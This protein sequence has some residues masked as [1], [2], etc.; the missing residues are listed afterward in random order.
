MSKTIL[1]VGGAGYIGSHTN[2]AL[3]EKGYKTIV[4]DN[5]SRGHLSAVSVDSEF[6]QGDL[7][8]VESIRGVFKTH[9]IDGV[10]DFAAS[11]E[12]GESQLNPQLYYYNNVVNSLNLFQVMLEFG[13]KNIVFSSTAATYGLPEVTPITESTPNKPINTYG[14]TKLMIEQILSDYHRA[15]NLNSI[16]LRYFNACGADLNLRTGEDHNPE[17]HLIPLIFQSISGKR[18]SI[19][20]FGSDYKTPDGTCVRDYIHV[21]DLAEA[22]ILAL[23]KMFNQKGF[24]EII[25]LGTGKGFSNLEIVRMVEKVTNL[26]V[27]LKMGDR[28][29]G[30]PDILVANNTKAREILNWEPK[31]SDLKNII[32]SAWN[33][34]TKLNQI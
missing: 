11:I 10:I 2:Y 14:R 22:H 33:W 13:V 28:R 6:I 21:M 7:V 17:S 31:N 12:V 32:Q 9:K 27:P 16:C 8:D 20:I 1:V 29:L 4:F 18:D 3:L 26:K 34:Y 25:N 15:Y 5:L 30:D 23:E 19:T 24:C